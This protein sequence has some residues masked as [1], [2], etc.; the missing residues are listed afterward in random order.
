L[1]EISVAD[2]DSLILDPDQDSDT[3]FDDPKFKQNLQL[4]KNVMKFFV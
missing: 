3:A 1:Q 4:K 2:L